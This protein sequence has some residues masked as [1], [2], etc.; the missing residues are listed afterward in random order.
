[1]IS[2]KL[3]LAC[4]LGL[5]LGVCVV[6]LR[7]FWDRSV[8]SLEDAERLVALPG[9]GSVP[10][11]KL[12]AAARAVGA[13]R[14]LVNGAGTKACE[15]SPSSAVSLVPSASF[16]P[17]EMHLPVEM[18]EAIRNVCASILLSQSDRELR[19]IV[20]TSAVPEE[21][22]TTIIGQVARALA[23]SGARTLLVDSDLRNP[24]LSRN[25]GVSGE[26]GLSL[27]LAGHVS[28]S[29]RIHKTDTE[30]LFLVGAGPQPPN[31]AALFNS[32]RMSLFLKEMAST[33]GYR[34]VLLDAPPVLPVADAR[35]LCSKAD[36]VVMV[37]RARR[38]ARNLL[39]RARDIL[40]NSGANLLGIVLNGADNDDQ[41]SSYY[42]NYYGKAYGNQ[43]V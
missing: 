16:L 8:P 15:V 7:D 43:P 29:P 41:E 28:P 22:K 23:D 18:T 21:G 12:P 17:Q 4:V 33:A 35:V 2:R 6:L 3:A 31:P 38:T 34:F 20:I 9:L 1:V 25:F 13:L 40:D 26:N 19:V 11:V 42:R 37:V 32:D 39:L 24:G 36:G 30:N 27:F 14:Q 5:A 10:L